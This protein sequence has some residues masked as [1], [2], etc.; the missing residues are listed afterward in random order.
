MLLYMQKAIAATQAALINLNGDSGGIAYSSS[1][2]LVICDLV[3]RGLPLGWQAAPVP[4]FLRIQV[5]DMNKQTR[6]AAAAMCVAALLSGCGG[7]AA[8]GGLY[9]Y[10]LSEYIE[11]GQYKGLEMPPSKYGLTEQRVK[12]RIISTL[13]NAEHITY[14][15]EGLVHEWDGVYMTYTETIDGETFDSATAGTLIGSG[16]FIPDFEEGLV[17]KSVGEAFLLKLKF[18]DN[19]NNVYERDFPDGY[20]PPDLSG[21]DAEYEITVNYVN[22]TGDLADYV[23]KSGGYSSVEEFVESVR[24]ELEETQEWLKRL[25]RE[26][27]ILKTL[28][29]TS[30]VLAYPEQEV[31][32]YIDMEDVPNKNYAK[33]EGL[34]WKDYLM[35]RMD[36]MTQEAYDK[37]VLEKARQQVA[38]EMMFM[39]IA[40]KEGLEYNLTVERVL[41]FI[42]GDA[43]PNP[44]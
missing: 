26:K 15:T 2:K 5:S 37:W 31:N 19:C 41:E 20:D 22:R 34:P 29:E 12:E 9:D 27:F 7:E 42:I 36:G 30:T 35:L 24:N 40:R 43:A 39:A 6:A 8:P 4:V 38:K 18:P 16:D 32:C 23:A 33:M 14:L 25:D 21:K 1:S 3:F 10:D 17:G 44:Q 13:V 28:T 11:L